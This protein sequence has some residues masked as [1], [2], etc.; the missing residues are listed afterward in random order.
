MTQPESIQEALIRIEILAFFQANP[1]TRDTAYGLASRLHR[2]PQGIQKACD[3]LV[4]LGILQTNNNGKNQIYRLKNGEYIIEF[5][6]KNKT[7][8]LV[9]NMENSRAQKGFDTT[10]GNLS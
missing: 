3:T 1:H 7:I 10:G 8:D 9:L 5:Y 6:K 2:S 4:N